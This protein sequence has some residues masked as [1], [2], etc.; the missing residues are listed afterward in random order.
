MMK[1]AILMLGIAAA[2]VSFSGWVNE[3]QAQHSLGG[4]FDG[5]DCVAS[6]GSCLCEPIV[7]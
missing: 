6:A 2:S 1:S 7:I 3:V 5:N 4:N